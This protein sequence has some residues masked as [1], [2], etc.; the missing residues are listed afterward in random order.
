MTRPDRIFSFGVFEFHASSGELR[1][2]G[3]RV[4][5]EPQPARALALLLTH[6]GEAVSREAMKDAVWGAETHV[7]F[8]RGLAY[9]V[10][11]I[12]S[13]LGDSADNPRFVQTLPRKG[14]KFIAPVQASPDSRVMPALDPLTPPIDPSITQA[15][16]TR[17]WWLWLG[18]GALLLLGATP[19]L[20]RSLNPPGPSVIAVSIFDNETGE[21]EH[22]LRVTTLSDT[23]VARLLQLDGERLAV[24][25]NAA[26]LRRPRNIRNLETL[27]A[28]IQAD[29][30]LLGQLQRADTGLRFVT[31]VIRLSDQAH[32]RANQLDFPDG[33][34]SRLETE[35]VGEFERAIRDHVLD[36]R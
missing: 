8:D 26:P 18:V 15:E 30:V 12:R 14:Y 21:P 25:G 2:N 20:L 23:V 33:D 6:P 4:A 19:N 13:A 35:V 9:V 29:Y 22:D 10:S 28:E 36:S 5:L 7:D 16:R 24:V 34:L 27:R 3:R 17:R 31:H 32:L 11:Q 1:R